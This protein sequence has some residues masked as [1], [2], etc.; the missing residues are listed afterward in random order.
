M[1][2]ASP[3]ALMQLHKP[4]VYW[5]FRMCPDRVVAAF[6]QKS[7]PPAFSYIALLPEKCELPVAPGDINDHSVSGSC[8]FHCQFGE[9]LAGTDH[10]IHVGAF[11]LHEHTD[12]SAGAGFGRSDALND[13]VLSRFIKKLLAREERKHGFETVDFADRR[14]F[15]SQAPGYERLTI[16]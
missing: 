14:V 3:K 8:F 13:L 15:E 4:S 2:N 7:G 1:A 6:C 5:L 9:D 12:L 11:G 10:R 16:T